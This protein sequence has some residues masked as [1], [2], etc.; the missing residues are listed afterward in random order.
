[1][2]LYQVVS[3]RTR[4]R[5]PLCGHVVWEKTLEN[6][7]YNVDIFAMDCKKSKGKGHGRNTFKFYPMVDKTF[8]QRVLEFLYRKVESLE[9]HLRI[10]IGGIE[11]RKS[12]S[13]WIRTV[14]TTYSL[15]TT[16]SSN[17]QKI[18]VTPSNFL[19]ISPT[20]SKHIQEL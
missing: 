14:P 19:Q 10:Q 9:Q 20:K 17:N 13:V 5:C 2:L 3:M 8:K 12:S 1:M 16:G 7:P 11:W 4:L 15:T 6:S 18:N